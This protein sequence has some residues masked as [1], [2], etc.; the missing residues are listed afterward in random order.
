[1]ISYQRNHSDDS[2]NRAL[3]NLGLKKN[4]CNRFKYSLTTKINSFL[5]NTT[6]EN[7]KLL[8]ELISYASISIF[9]FLPIFTLFL[10]GI[11]IRRKFTYTEHLIFV[12]HTQTVFF[13]LLTLFFSLGLISGNK[14]IIGI[15]TGLFPLYLFLAMKKFYQQGIFKTF[16][17]LCILSAIFLVMAFIGLTILYMISFVTY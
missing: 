15:F 8:R 17:K 10:R 6:E 2:I 1:M 12:F 14:N 9:I 5:T 11:Y 13:I 16:L 3:D 4:F 7:K